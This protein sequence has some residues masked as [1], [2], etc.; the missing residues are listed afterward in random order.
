MKSYHSTAAPVYALDWPFNATAKLF[1]NWLIMFDFKLCLISGDQAHDIV[2][3]Y[4]N[5]HNGKTY[6]GICGM[7]WTDNIKNQLHWQIYNKNI[8]SLNM[9]VCVYYCR[10]SV[11]GSSVSPQGVAMV[12]SV[13]QWSYA[14]EV[15]RPVEMD[16]ISVTL[17]VTRVMCAFIAGRLC[18]G[19]CFI[20][21][22]SM[23][24][25]ID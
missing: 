9:F 8:Y 25:Y 11:S 13:L 10:K 24:T 5:K 23:C 22:S 2:L 20:K 17:R 6:W 1:I 3:K 14:L 21:S 4:V 7:V 15:W 18:C 16:H 12:T 19:I